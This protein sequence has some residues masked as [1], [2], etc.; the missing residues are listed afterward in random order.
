MEP[1]IRDRVKSGSFKR[2]YY[3]P[4]WFLLEEALDTED[5]SAL[6]GEVFCYILLILVVI[7]PDHS[8][9]YKVESAAYFTFLQNGVAFLEL[10][11]HKDAAQNLDGL[12]R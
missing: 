6:E 3:K 10:H 8:F 1:I 9:L 7:L 4:T 12:R 11:G 2:F 5:D